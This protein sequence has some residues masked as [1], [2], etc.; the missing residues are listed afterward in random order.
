MPAGNVP[1]L[2]FNIG[3][4]KDNELDRITAF[5]MAGISVCKTVIFSNRPHLLD[6]AYALQ[7][8]VPHINLTGRGYRGIEKELTTA[9]RTGWIYGGLLIRRRFATPTGTLAQKVA[10]SAAVLAA[11]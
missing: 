9:F 3:L 2:R 10:Q 1:Y 11:P 8:Y 7:H 6:R 4:N 5:D